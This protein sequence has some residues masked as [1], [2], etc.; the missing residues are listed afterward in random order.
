MTYA[1]LISPTDLRDYAKVRG[2]TSVPE[3]VQDRLFVL[4]S[5]KDQY[6]QV[7]V[8]MD[9]DRPDFD[10]ALRVAITRLAEVEGRG[11]GMVEAS[12]MEAGSD[13]WRF[14]VTTMRHAE[15]GLPLSY[16]A[17]AVKGVENAFRAAACSE[18]QRQAFHPKMNRA[19]AQKLIQ[20]AQMRHTESGSF[21][22]KVACPIDAI[23]SEDGDEKA[24]KLPFVRRAMLGMSDAVHRLISS[25]EA[26]TLEKLVEE[27]KLEGTSPLSSNLCEG[28]L[29]FQ[30][31][32]LKANLDL[33]VAW[34]SRLESPAQTHLK[35]TRIQWDYFPSIEQVRTALRPAQAAK[36]QAFV[37]TVTNLGGDFEPGEQMQGEVILNLLVDGESVEAKVNLS[38]E[39]HKLAY[40]AYAP[41]KPYVQVVGLLHPGNE[42]RKLTNVSGFVILGK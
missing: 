16:A 37:G 29:A 38:A 15:D 3:A 11:F 28:L 42:P 26:D 39:Y 27:A 41:P 33:S 36:E 34:S 7:I 9:T 23:P 30:Y 10:D 20:A 31:E 8:P 19:E 2:W 24:S 17:R 4:K 22:L 25:L 1:D 14:G 18:V 40:Q 35:K 32:D 6:R 5:P 21:V 12:L 13:T